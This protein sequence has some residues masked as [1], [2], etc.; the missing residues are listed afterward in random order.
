LEYYD[1][2]KTLTDEEVDKE[3][4]KAIENVKKK[5]NAQLRG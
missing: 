2:N 3:F 5:F 4:W 1:F